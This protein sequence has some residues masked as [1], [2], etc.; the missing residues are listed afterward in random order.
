MHVSESCHKARSGAYLLSETWRII[1]S[2][3][4]ITAVMTRTTAAS[5]IVGTIM[6]ISW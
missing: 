4:S 1:T 5:A 6:S 3:H 2:D